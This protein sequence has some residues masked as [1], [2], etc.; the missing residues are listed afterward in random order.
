MKG[1]PALYPAGTQG[2]WGGMDPDP[3]KPGGV[4]KRQYHLPFGGFD[5]PTQL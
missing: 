4:Q 2:A 5:R 3:L 1:A